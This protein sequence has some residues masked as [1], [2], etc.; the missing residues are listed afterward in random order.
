MK[1][2]LAITISFMIY[3]MYKENLQVSAHQEAMWD[4]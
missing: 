3:Y 1:L 2:V 4:L